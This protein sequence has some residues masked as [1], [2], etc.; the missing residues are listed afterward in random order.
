MSMDAEKNKIY[1]N[2]KARRYIINI[3]NHRSIVALIAGLV[4]LNCAIYAVVYGI[5]KYVRTGNQINEFFRY[6]T[7][8]ANIFAAIGSALIIPYAIDGVRKKR[9]YCPKWVVFF[10]YCGTVCTTLVMIFAV[11]LIG[12]T[13]PDMAFHGSNFYL[14]LICPTLIFISFLFIESYYKLTIKDVFKS[15]IPIFIYAMVYVYEVIIIGADNGGW[16]DVYYFTIYAP[17][18]V[19]FILMMVMSFLVASGV[20]LIYNKL[21]EYR[22]KK[23]SDNLWDKN[24]SKVEI[25]IEFFGLGRYIGKKEN[26]TY[27]TLPL[28]IMSIVSEKYNIKREELIGAF[29]KGLLDSMYGN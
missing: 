18:V 17:A 27:A 21:S 12:P 15:I 8:C 11:C 1:Q 6:F 22:I 29:T 14:H 9:F 19:S 20:R 25:K 4:S 13:N 10:Y 5:V 26:K 28:D 24:T 2:V 16:D 7:T 23:F 3:Q